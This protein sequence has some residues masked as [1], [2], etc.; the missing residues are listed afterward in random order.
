MELESIFSIIMASIV[1]LTEFLKGLAAKFAPK[2]KLTPQIL[3]I[4]S[5]VVV[6]AI[7]VFIV[8]PE[9][10]NLKGALLFSFLA[11]SGLYGLLVK[12]LK[13]MLSGSKAE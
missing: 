8:R 11:S 13:E 3:Q 10:A 6:V 1:A 9:L 7:V 5:G 2:L 4:I 12:P